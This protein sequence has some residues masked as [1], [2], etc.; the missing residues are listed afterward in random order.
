MHVGVVIGASVVGLVGSF[1]PN[2]SWQAAIYSGTFAG[3]SSTFVVG[4]IGELLLTSITGGLLLILL[5]RKF[6]GVGGKLG[7]TAFVSVLSLIAIKALL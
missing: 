5:E 4:G 7:A 3:M 2:K 6:I 1:V